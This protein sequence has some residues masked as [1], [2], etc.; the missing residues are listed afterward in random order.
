MCRFVLGTISAQRLGLPGANVSG[1]P[2][3]HGT[4]AAGPD[5]TPAEDPSLNDLSTPFYRMRFGRDLRLA[6]VCWHNVL[7]AI[8]L[9]VHSQSVSCLSAWKEPGCGT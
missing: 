8:L 9:C 4:G 5:R 1:I 2:A 3:E 6:E 7:L